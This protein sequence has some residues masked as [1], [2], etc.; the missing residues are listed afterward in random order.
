MK[1]FTNILSQATIDKCMA[2]AGGVAAVSGSLASGISSSM[3]SGGGSGSGGGGSSGGGGGGGGG[4]G[5]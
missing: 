5:R 3:P 4:G 1:K 2:C